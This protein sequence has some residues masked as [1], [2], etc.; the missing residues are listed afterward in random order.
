MRG[1]LPLHPLPHSPER[2]AAWKPPTATL[3][4]LSRENPRERARAPHGGGW[5][6]H[7]HSPPISA[8][9]TAVTAAASSSSSQVQ[10]QQG[11]Q[12]LFQSA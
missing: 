1:E 12:S 4:Q 7:C 3:L 2:Q 8:A 5:T 6:K 10:R 11:S 9:S